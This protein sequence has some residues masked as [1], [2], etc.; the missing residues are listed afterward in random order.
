MSLT[1]VLNNVRPS[2]SVMTISVPR[3]DATLQ[4]RVVNTRSVSTELLIFSSKSLISATLF[5][6]AAMFALNVESNIVQ[7]TGCAAVPYTAAKC[8]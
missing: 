2:V 4:Q 8:L 1:F 3:P 5:D 6:D 7:Y